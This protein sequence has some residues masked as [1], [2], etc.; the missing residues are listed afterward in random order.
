M[1][2]SWFGDNDEKSVHN[3]VLLFHV[4]TP[5][6]QSAVLYC[7]QVKEPNRPRHAEI[8]IQMRYQ[9]VKR[10]KRL[11][12][13]QCRQ[14]LMVLWM[15]GLPSS[16]YRMEGNGT[17]CPRS[18]H[19]RAREFVNVTRQSSSW[20]TMTRLENLASEGANANTTSVTHPCLQ[21]KRKKVACWE[22]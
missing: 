6:H 20:Q 1:I 8:G 10:G 14:S 15:H 18:V 9:C 19:V 13:I 4:W 5:R 16:S 12:P 22:R 17:D 21:T 3:G 11:T 2:I 7:Y